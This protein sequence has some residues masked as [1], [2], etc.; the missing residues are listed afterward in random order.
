[1]NSNSNNSSI[2]ANLIARELGD[3]WC[4][5]DTDG[6]IWHPIEPIADA[7]EARRACHETPS[8]G[9]WHS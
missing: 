9:V 1:M 8:A 6:G 4:V 5:E 3:S 2:P 7:D